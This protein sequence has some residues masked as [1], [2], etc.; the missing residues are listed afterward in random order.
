MNLACKLP[1]KTLTI[2]PVE[3]LLTQKFID[4]LESHKVLGLNWDMYGVVRM[5]W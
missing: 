1:N 3:V 2:I 4:Y 5:S